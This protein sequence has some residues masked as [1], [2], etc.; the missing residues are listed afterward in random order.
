[1]V[2]R[3]WRASGA[4]EL[5]CK[6]SITCTVTRE[7]ICGIIRRSGV[8]ASRVQQGGR[9]PLLLRESRCSVRSRRDIVWEST[10]TKKMCVSV[11]LV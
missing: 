1:M 10:C 4:I 3:V 6:V 7:A 11:V 5:E 8:V 9:I 2:A